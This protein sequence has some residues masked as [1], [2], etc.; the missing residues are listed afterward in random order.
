M[1]LSL[2]AHGRDNN[3]QL[4]RF[5][6]ATAVILFHSY[7]LTNHW[8]DEPLWRLAPEL[9]F[10]SLGVKIFFVVS[11]FLVTGSWE[12]RRRLA[13]FATARALRIYPGLV[14]ATLFTIAVAGA[15]ST[16]PFGAFIT[17]PATFDY[18]WRTALGWELR[19]RLPGA[20]ASNPFPDA[21]NG[22]MWTLPIELRLYVAVAVAGLA[23]LLAR[24]VAW[25]AAI[26]VA[27]TI[28]V[29]QPA[30]FPLAPNDQVTRELALLFALGSLAWCWRARVVVSLPAALAALAVIAWN[31]A[32]I[33]RG[34]LLEPLLAYVVLVAAYHPMLQWP[35]FNRAGDYS[36]GLYVY[37]FP[38][39]QLLVQ[40]LPGATPAR[41]FA[42]AMP[43][44]LVVAALSWHVV[45]K[46]ALGLKSRFRRPPEDPA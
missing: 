7:A 3:F 23:G 10:G 43:A 19:D 20:F 42:L 33:G 39:Q 24:R 30:W 9:N 22:S 34:P 13:P 41:L 40:F 46:P 1:R 38:M 45:E 2:L 6:A 31:P 28:F 14:A 26:A 29:A 25:L 8:T 36:Y 5:F 4:L 18:A 32:G 44:A 16:V 21:V 17:D 37:S 27:T 11:G 35:A 12:S 15:A